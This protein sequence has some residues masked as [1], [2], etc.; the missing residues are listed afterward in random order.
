M[1]MMMMPII[2]MVTPTSRG[3]FHVFVRVVVGTIATSLPV[4]VSGKTATKEEEE[5]EAVAVADVL[6]YANGKRRLR[7]GGAK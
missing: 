5:S 4:D 7:N 6:I 3:D 1:M 2:I